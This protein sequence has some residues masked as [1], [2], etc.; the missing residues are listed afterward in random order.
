MLEN[1]RP[2]VRFSL[3]WKITL[4]FIVLAL[5]LGLGLGFL[6]NQ[7]LSKAEEVSFQRQLRDSGQQAADEVVRIE[8]RLL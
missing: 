3:R 6:V 2:R 8:E 4:P 5:A 1:E 7:Q